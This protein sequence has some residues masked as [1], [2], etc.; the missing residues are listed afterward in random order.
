MTGEAV[1]QTERWLTDWVI[2]HDLCPFAR[3]P[4]DQGRVRIVAT[5]ATDSDS[6]FRFILG[7]LDNLY[8]ADPEK[9][10]TTLVVVEQLLM[11]FDDYL[12]FL[13]LLQRV[14][15][16]TGLE[17]EIQI[18]SFHP[19]YQFEGVEKDDPSNYTNRSPYPLFHLIREASLE[20]AIAHYPEPEKT[21]QRNIAL[22]REMGIDKVKKQL[23]E[24]SS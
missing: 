7:E 3:Y 2:R 10:E 9:I 24:I 6:V 19:D 22:M 18:A 13:D 21:P 11:N 23:Q 5:D 1:K 17:G 15:V 16:E 12:D 14:I 20:K 8:Q 4:Y